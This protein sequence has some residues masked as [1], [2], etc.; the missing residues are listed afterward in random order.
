MLEQTLS[1]ITGNKSFVKSSSWTH[2]PQIS[3]VTLGFI[4][5]S[6]HSGVSSLLA[7]REIEGKIYIY[8]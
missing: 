7:K 6:D 5:Q 8:F 1:G 2:F 4:Y 3:L